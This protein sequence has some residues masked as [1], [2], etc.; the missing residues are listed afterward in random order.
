[1]F[2]ESGQLHGPSRAEQRLH[3]SFY[4][5]SAAIGGCGSDRLVTGRAHGN[6]DIETWIGTG[7]RRGGA[8]DSPPWGVRPE[9]KNR[10]IH[11]VRYQ[12]EYTADYAVSTEAPHDNDARHPHRAL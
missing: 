4:V 5:P 7:G 6:D 3:S 9:P 10:G 2:P 8:C 12:Y 11:C 1:M